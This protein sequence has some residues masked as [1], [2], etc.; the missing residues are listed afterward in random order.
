[1][2]N[3]AGK[4]GL[5]VGTGRCG[6]KFISQIVAREDGVSSVHER[7][8][9]NET[10]HRYCKWYNLPVDDEGFLKTKEDEVNSDLVNH[11]YSFEAS[12]FL[13]LSLVELYERFGAKIVLLVRQPDRVINSYLRKG[14]YSKPYIYKN[15]DLAP[16]Y[17][18]EERFHHF[19][20]RI[21]PTGKE[22]LTWQNLTRVG[23]L[24]WY[25]Q[26]LNRSVLE[27][28]EQIPQSHCQVIR[29]ED[30]DYDRYLQ[31]A[32]FLGYQATVNKSLYQ[33]IKH[34]RPNKQSHLPKT[35]LWEDR[36]R[37]EFES[38]VKSLAKTFGY[39]ADI[40]ALNTEEPLPAQS[41]GSFLGKLRDLL[42]R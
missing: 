1:M 38:Y 5:A 24:A 41:Y 21:V 9:L 42:A 3:Y 25:W 19:L 37:A 16:G 4:V 36:E 30:L 18:Q 6:T 39:P 22:F 34:S 27:Q 33:K 32:S 40:D 13:S 26:T 2:A 15:P 35:N 7:N 14:W 31:V 11:R 28:F 17:Q 20:G 23:K 29:I 10:F 8:P 12:A